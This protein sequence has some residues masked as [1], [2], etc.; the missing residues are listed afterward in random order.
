MAPELRVSCGGYPYHPP[1]D[2]REERE[3]SRLVVYRGEMYPHEIVLALHR[4]ARAQQR[5]RLVRLVVGRVV[6]KPLPANMIVGFLEPRRL[7]L[8][9]DYLAR[10]RVPAD[11]VWLTLRR[12]FWMYGKVAVPRNL[13]ALVAV[14]PAHTR[15]A[16]TAVKEEEQ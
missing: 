6:R 5:L 1:R 11:Q 8:T 16:E 9:S 15:G 13:R 2:A 12:W 3:E 4:R 7:C 14:D 10:Q